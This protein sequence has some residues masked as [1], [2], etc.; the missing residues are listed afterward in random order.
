MISTVSTVFLNFHILDIDKYLKTLKNQI[1]EGI[2]ILYDLSPLYISLNLG[3][4]GLNDL[5]NLND[6]HLIRKMGALVIYLWN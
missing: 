2:S 3:Q 6:F 4:T 5:T 1:R